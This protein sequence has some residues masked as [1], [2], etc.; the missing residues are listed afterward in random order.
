[1][2]SERG[3]RNNRAGSFL[4]IENGDDGH[5]VGKIEDPSHPPKN[6]SATSGTR[7]Q[8]RNFW[9]PGASS[10]RRARGVSTAAGLGGNVDSSATP[11]DEDA[12]P[13]NTT[14]TT[15]KTPRTS[16]SSSQQHRGTGSIPRRVMGIL[17]TPFRRRR[18][19]TPVVKANLQ[20]VDEQENLAKMRNG[21]AGLA[22]APAAGP[23]LSGKTSSIIPPPYINKNEDQHTGRHLHHLQ[24]HSSDQ[25]VDDDHLHQRTFSCQEQGDRVEI[26]RYRVFFEEAGGGLEIN[27]CGAEA[28]HVEVVL[29]PVREDG[30]LH[31]TLQRQE[32]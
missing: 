26:Y 28:D 20:A 14:T 27:N 11:T 18:H 29:H 32:G 19:T 13:A 16:K 9:A 2:T 1:K 21:D 30:E 4:R 17:G 22:G 15:F 7:S 12:I 24:G 3:R 25:E 6:G 31:L 8:T 5:G 23:L 10:R